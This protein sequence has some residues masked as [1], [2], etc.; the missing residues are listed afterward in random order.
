[1]ANANQVQGTPPDKP[2]IVNV[3]QPVGAAAA[4]AP[5]GKGMS[6]ASLVLG[7]V[8]LVNTPFIPIT[9]GCWSLFV[10]PVAIV[11][12][13][14]GIIGKNKLKA[15]GNPYGMA[16]AGIVM[17]IIPLGLA[18]II[19]V[20]MFIVG[21]AGQNT[22]QQYPIALAGSVV[23]WFVMTGHARLALLSP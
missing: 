7:I 3:N 1:M 19:T 20:F 12:L 8:A 16:I 11:G 23:V 4:P 6:I 22:N 13:I 18:A 14:L 5:P 9:L 10:I 21:A 15:A 2:V 17:S